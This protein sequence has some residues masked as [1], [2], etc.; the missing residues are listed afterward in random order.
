MSN[1]DETYSEEETVKRREAALTRMLNTPHKPQKP[2]GLTPMKNKKAQPHKPNAGKGRN[3]R[4][5]SK[6]DSG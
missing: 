2:M 3:D 6:G 5:A 4:G 1:T